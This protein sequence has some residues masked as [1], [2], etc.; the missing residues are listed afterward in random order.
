LGD[1]T[2]IRVGIAWAACRKA[3]M[4]AAVE[5]WAMARERIPGFFDRV[6]RSVM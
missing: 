1:L 3:R 4:V 5:R 6:N 2:A